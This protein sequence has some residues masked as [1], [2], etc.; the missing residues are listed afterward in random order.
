MIGSRKF[1]QGGPRDNCVCRNFGFLLVN[2]INLIFSGES[3]PPPPVSEPSLNPRVSFVNLRKRFDNKWTE[4]QNSVQSK[5][6]ND[7]TDV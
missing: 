1:D 3:G 7:I 4:N 5:S 6:N 2:L